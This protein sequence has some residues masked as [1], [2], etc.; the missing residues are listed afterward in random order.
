MKLF[1]ITLTAVLLSGNAM[2]GTLVNRSS[3]EKLSST[4]LAHDEN[5]NCIRL[6]LRAE[7]E[8]GIRIKFLEGND[9]SRTYKAIDLPEP[10]LL[11]FM[12]PMEMG[13]LTGSWLGLILTLPISLPIGATLDLYWV[14]HM[15]SA[16][17]VDYRAVKSIR[18][19]INSEKTKSKT[20][21]KKMFNR[22]VK[23]MNLLRS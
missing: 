8:S 17:I 1:L 11:L 7:L 12:A 21:S 2:A 4:C 20:I 9:L 13:E 3:N 18:L 6:E 16:R 10:T 15:I 23:K 22:I 19:L 5:K 14:P